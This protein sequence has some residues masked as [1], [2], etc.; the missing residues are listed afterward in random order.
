MI[1]SIGSSGYSQSMT[2]MWGQKSRPDPEE[3]AQEL[4]TSTDADGSGGI[5]LEE[6]TEAIA[7]KSDGSGNGPDAEELF[8]SMDTDGDGVVTEE[9]HEAGLA[10]MHKDLAQASMLTSMSMTSLA[11]E[12]FSETDA[13]G[14]G[15]ITAEELATA[16]AARNEETG[17]TVDADALFELLDADGD[18]SITAEEHAEGL[19]SMGGGEQTQAMAPPAPPAGGASSEEEDDSFDAADT[20]EDGVVSAEELLASLGI[21]TDGDG[22]LSAAEFGSV[23]SG[24]SSS[25]AT[26]TQQSAFSG[27]N[28]SVMASQFEM[29]RMMGMDAQSMMFGGGLNIRA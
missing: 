21:D 7:A 17:G 6:M 25:S 20:N 5:T 12:L 23:L 4:F 22:S 1:S 11:D 24:L 27:M 29:Y 28:P 10:S 15:A 26:Q 16:I 9:E 8:N 19:A 13:D 2:A 3:M 14:D 18:G